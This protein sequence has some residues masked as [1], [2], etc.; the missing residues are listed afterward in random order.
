VVTFT[1]ALAWVLVGVIVIGGICVFVAGLIVKRETPYV[2]V[3]P[4]PDD[5]ELR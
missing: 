2:I 3:D 4:D 1:E 5:K